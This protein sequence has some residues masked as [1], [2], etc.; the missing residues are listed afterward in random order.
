MCYWYLF[1][2]FLLHSCTT[3]KPPHA[4]LRLAFATSPATFH[5]QKASDFT[6]T[7]L[8]YLLYDGL[9]RCHHEKDFEM[10]LANELWI[11]EDQT[12][13]RFTLKTAYWSDGT[14]ITAYDFE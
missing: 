9:T 12:L 7:T 11:S 10:A 13:Y 14:P 4:H 6:S 5:P 3:P 1:L 2:F 8:A